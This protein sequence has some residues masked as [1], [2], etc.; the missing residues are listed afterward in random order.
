MKK[1]KLFVKNN[2]FILILGVFVVLNLLIGTRLYSFR[3]NN[4]DFGKFD[5]GNM[6]QM[7]WNTLHGRVLYMT[8]Y[9]GS[10][11][12]RWAMSHVDPIILIFV[13]IFALFQH[14]MTLAYSQL[15]LVVFAAF[16]VYGIAYMELKSKLAACLFGITY[17]MYPALG[18]INGTMGFHGVTASIP[19]FL[20]AFY[21]FEKMYRDGF[22]R[23]GTIILWILLVI[24]MSGKE[25]VPLYIFMWGIFIL[26]FRT[27]LTDSFRFSK[28]WFKK[29]FSQPSVKNGIA[30]IVIGLLWFS[31][32]FF[33]VIPK[34]APLRVASYNAFIKSLNIGVRNNS[35]VTLE[36]YF[37]GRYSEFG[38]SYKDVV[39]NIFLHPG[40]SIRVFFSDD[41]LVNLRMTFMPL[42]YAPLANPAM[43]LIAA[44]EF[45][46]NYMT[47]QS[48]MGISD[49]SSHRISMIIPVLVIASIYAVGFISKSLQQLIKK[50]NMD[51]KV[52]KITAVV[53]S[54]AILVSIFIM[55]SAY[56]NPVYLWFTQAVARR[57]HA[58]FDTNI[59]KRTDLKSGDAVKI[60]DIDVQDRTCSQAIISMIPAEVSV[61]GPDNLGAQLS[62]R[63][64]YALFPG[65]WDS[66]DYVIVD[67]LSRKVAGILQLDNNIVRDV[68]EMLLTSNN[69]KLLMSCGNLSL[70]KKVTPN[71]TNGSDEFP[72]QERFQ[73]AERFRY[74]LSDYVTIVDY[75]LPAKVTR[76]EAQK[77]SITFL[78][79]EFSTMNGFSLYTT[80]INKKTGFVFQVADLPSFAFYKPEDW[81]K[82]LY[83]V[84]NIEIALPS[85]VEPGT[86][87]VFV[88]LTNRI[89]SWSVYLGDLQVN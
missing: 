84:D 20:G 11:V 51:G 77:A 30:M 26:I 73:Y 87:D 34:Y 68:T 2:I 37:L 62:L 44:P 9:F 54:G 80:Y 75:S 24:T 25:Q 50:E 36:N 19:F 49:I 53:L 59:I 88:S 29:W 65:L 47:T 32:A 74:L 12:P 76:T 55:D 6:A 21:L 46:I 45:F 63:E 41:N 48:D 7:A 38:Q 3:Y 16:F 13:P 66:A 15:A 69:H 42:L 71:I 64:T 79:N 17:L 72:I 83:Y 52:R 18:F 86:Y 28:E 40:N 22:T 78:R 4:F 23:R 85:Y 58:K 56:S 67:V 43:L 61:S 70:F 31:V 82:G 27:G 39:F 1:A 33:V 10:N 5:Q 60:T 8:D 81:G 35:T 14:P 57:V 89:K